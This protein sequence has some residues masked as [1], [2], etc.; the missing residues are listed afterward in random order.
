MA[1]DLIELKGV[2]RGTTIELE[3]ETGLPTGSRIRLWLVVETP[4]APNPL[5]VTAEEAAA[6][7]QTLQAIYRMRH[8]GRSILKP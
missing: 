1:D 7:E 2:V 8:T 6:A 5:A 4:K 3:E